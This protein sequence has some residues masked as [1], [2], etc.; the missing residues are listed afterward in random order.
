VSKKHRSLIRELRKER[1]ISQ[2]K[3]SAKSGAS[4]RTIYAMEAGK[5]TRVFSRRKVLEAL[6]LDYFKDKSWVFPK[7]HIGVLI[8]EMSSQKAATILEKND[9]DELSYYARKILDGLISDGKALE[10]TSGSEDE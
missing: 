8:V 1:G 5:R 2:E 6:G 9:K 3:L 10:I 4:L 7:D